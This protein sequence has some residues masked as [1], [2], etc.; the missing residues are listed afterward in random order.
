MKTDINICYLINDSFLKLTLESINYIK[1]FFKSKKHNLKFY[2]IGINDFN[3]PDDITFI[4]SSHPELPILWQRMYIPDMVGVDKLIF[5]DSDTVTTTCI[6]KLWDT[7]LND[8]VIGA[9]QHAIVNNV[10]YIISKWGLNFPPFT[11]FKNQPYFNCGVILMD[12]VKW[13]EQNIT[14]KCIDMFKTY[15]NSKYRGWDEPAWNMALMNNWKRLDDM[16]NYYPGE[17]GE[18]KRAYITHYYGQSNTRKP[19]HNMFFI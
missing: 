13:N 5:I 7:D 16:W 11:E 3:V 6:S 15:D 10:D 2:I 19:K 18:Y 1:K 14:Q 12:C 17:G 9:A 8:N 4:K